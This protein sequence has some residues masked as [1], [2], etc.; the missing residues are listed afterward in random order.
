MKDLHRLVYTSA[1][2]KSCTDDEIQ[3]ILASC[4]K[5]NVGLSITGLLLHTN[6]RFLQVVEGEKDVIVDLYEKIKGDPRHGGVNLRFL[7]PIDE[8][9]FGNWYMAFKDLGSDEIDFQTS[10]TSEA[11][12]TIQSMLLGEM[13]SYEDRGMKVLKAFISNT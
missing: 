11:K 3:N 6:R 9:A 4:K 8:R 12:K 2:H 1:R 10:V 5:N 13:S 7:E